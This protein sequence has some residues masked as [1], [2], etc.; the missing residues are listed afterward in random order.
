MVQH[1]KIDFVSDVA[2]P[3]CI[4]GLRGLQEALARTT[5]Q[6]QAEIVFQPFELNP[7]MPAEGQDL[8]EHVAE[9]YGST[10]EQSAANRATI[11]SRA[12]D[13]GF[14][15]TLAE[16]SR[17]HN[18]FDAHRLLYW[19]GTQGRQQPL[20]L[21]LFKANFTDGANVSDPDVLVAAA[22]SAGLDETAARDVLA[23]G[24]YAAEVREAEQLWL[25]RGINSVPAIVINEKWLI[26]GGQP[27]DAF[28][29]ALRD[30]AAE[31]S[32]AGRQA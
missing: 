31:L 24:R 7:D 18:T 17:I 12:A 8:A 10:A 32:D 2:C 26:S 27:A 16:H 29:S 6:V 3:W 9:K 5:D 13:V 4:I 15:F 14:E 30:I 25:S 28:E 21:A 11:R 20:K 23:S 19:A 22:V 1:L